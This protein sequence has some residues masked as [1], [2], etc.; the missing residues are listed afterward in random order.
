VYVEPLKGYRSFFEWIMSPVV[1]LKAPNLNL[2][3][4]CRVLYA[5]YS[6]E[7]K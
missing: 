3:I 1:A 4:G 5:T 6:P 7:N 2:S